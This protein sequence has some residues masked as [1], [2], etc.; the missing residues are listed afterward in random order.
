MKYIKGF[1]LFE[2]HYVDT[3]WEHDDNRL[4]ISDINEYLDK[5]LVDVVYIPVSDIKHMCVHINKRDDNTLK[6]SEGSDL[7]YPIIIAT[8]NGEY[9]RIL[10]GHHRLLKAINNGYDKIKARIFELND[11]P[12]IFKKIFDR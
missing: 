3:F 10:D 12:D 5:N 9:S 4:T 6:R 11:A 2:S 1:R 8:K 7:K